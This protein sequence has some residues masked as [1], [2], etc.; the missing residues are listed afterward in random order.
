IYNSMK[1][2]L[3]PILAKAAHEKNMRVSGHIPVHMRAEEAVRAGYDEIQHANMLF[4]NFFI[5]KDTDTRTPLRFSI[6]ADKAPDFD[7]KSKPALDFFQLLIDKKTVVDPTL[8][9]F[10]QLFV[11][12]PGEIPASFAPM[13]E[14][15]PVQVQRG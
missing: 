10:E 9:V 15:L 7:L 5:D 4:L 14:R 3:V 6:V 13:V 8:A 12:R 11:S 2:E 1:T